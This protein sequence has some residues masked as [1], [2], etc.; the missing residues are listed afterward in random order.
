MPQY[1]HICIEQVLTFANSSASKSILAACG[2]ARNP[3]SEFS[4]EDTKGGHN[5]VTIIADHLCYVKRR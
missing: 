4:G 2:F 1:R 5:G 3:I